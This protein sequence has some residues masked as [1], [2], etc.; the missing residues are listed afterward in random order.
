[1]TVPSQIA[2]RLSKPL[3]KRSNVNGPGAMKN[4][5]IQMGQWLTR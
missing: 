5:K 4:T 3:S 1:M 2:M